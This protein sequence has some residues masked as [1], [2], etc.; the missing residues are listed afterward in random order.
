MRYLERKTG[1]F[2]RYLWATGLVVWL[3]GESGRLTVSSH[4]SACMGGVGNH[5]WLGAGTTGRLQKISSFSLPAVKVPIS[6]FLQAECREGSSSGRIRHTIVYK[7]G[8]K[9]NKKKT[10]DLKTSP[11]SLLPPPRASQLDSILLGTK[12]R[13]EEKTATD[14]GGQPQDATE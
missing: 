6:P 10:S 11:S 1:R 5:V 12:R 2:S 13:S 7:E 3:P 9:G 8:Q 4:C 14:I